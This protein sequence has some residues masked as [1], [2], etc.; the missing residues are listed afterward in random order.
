M[1]IIL[2]S[3]LPKSIMRVYNIVNNTVDIFYYLIA[4]VS[5][6]ASGRCVS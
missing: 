2:I 6:A 3:I 1:T 5:E 4:A